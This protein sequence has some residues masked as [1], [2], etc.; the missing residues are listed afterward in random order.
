[1]TGYSVY[2]GGVIGG[3]LQWGWRCS[4]CMSD[5]EEGFVCVWWGGI[6]SVFTSLL[7]SIMYGYHNLVKPASLSK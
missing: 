5:S 6:V 4:I 1:M 7:A 3:H 2:G